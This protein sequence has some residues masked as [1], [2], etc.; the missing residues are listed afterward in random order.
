MK[1]REDDGDLVYD[2]PDDSAL[3]IFHPDDS[4]VILLE[5][6][7]PNDPVP[8]NYLLA[9]ALAIFLKNKDNVQLVLDTLPL[10]K[11]GKHKHN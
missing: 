2:V 7:A 8:K 3:L 4:M 6:L 11:D 1:L 9:S 5:T 10:K